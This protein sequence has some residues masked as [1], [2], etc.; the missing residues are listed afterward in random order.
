MKLIA[1]SLLLT[2][3]LIA[4]GSPGLASPS[5]SLAGLHY[6]IVYD[7]E[8]NSGVGYLEGSFTGPLSEPTIY[9]VPIPFENGA[10]TITS[11]DPASCTAYVEG[12]EMRVSLTE[13]I[14]SFKVYFL[15]EGALAEM[16]ALAYTLDIS[17]PD[18]SSVR[19]E[20][21]GFFDVI[22]YPEARVE[23]SNEST[24]I[25][26]S[27]PG[28]YSI[29]LYYPIQTPTEPTGSPSP[30][31]TT[32]TEQITS[33]TATQQPPTQTEATHTPTPTPSPVTTPTKEQREAGASGAY[34]Y[35]IILAIVIA[36]VFAWIALRKRG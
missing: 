5:Y 19:L 3:A 25:V 6:Y 20:I 31:L 26:L 15:V 18:K 1:I 36:A 8:N 2:L 32:T 22:A 11:V 14:T 17:V 13:N 27:S 30:A 28:Y 23:Y 34:I 4:I 16:G 7:P 24:I 29:T 35:G 21:M 9:V 10:L 12:G 33:P